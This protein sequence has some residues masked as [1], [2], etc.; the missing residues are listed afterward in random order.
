MSDDAETQRIIGQLQASVEGLQRDVHALRVQVAQLIEIAA[1]AK[2]GWKT[3]VA[4][5]TL[6]SAC[7]AAIIKFWAM[8]MGKG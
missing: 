7:T 2:G 5:G 3:L 4:V 8:L 6:T 1:V